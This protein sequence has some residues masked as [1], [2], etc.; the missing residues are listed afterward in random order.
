MLC[1][2]VGI[3]QTNKI[4]TRLLIKESHR[5]ILFLVV[6]DVNNFML[7]DSCCY[8]HILVIE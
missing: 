3:C 7:G 8:I 1:T 4:S 2:L 6:H 5:F